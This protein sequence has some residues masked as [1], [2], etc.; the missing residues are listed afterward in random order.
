MKTTRKILITGLLSFITIMSFGQKG[1]GNTMGIARNS[2]DYEQMEVSGT[3]EKIV[4][5]DCENTTGRYA[6]GTHMIVNTKNR[7]AETVNVHLGPSAQVAGMI[8]DLKK[9]ESIRIDAFQTRDLDDNHYIAKSF[10]TSEG[11]TIELRNDFLQPFWARS[12]E[13]SGRRRNGKG[14]GRKRGMLP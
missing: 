1:T 10:I 4:T 9:G 7:D 3:I 14:S 13:G 8:K 12:K 5:E 11:K 6:N 2:A